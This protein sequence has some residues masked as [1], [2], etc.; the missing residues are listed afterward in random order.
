MPSACLE[1]MCSPC[2]RRFL[3]Q[4]T[5]FPAGSDFHSHKVDISSKAAASVTSGEVAQERTQRQH[6]SSIGKSLQTPLNM[7]DG[8]TQ[9]HHISVTQALGNGPSP[10]LVYVRH[11]AH[12]TPLD[13]PHRWH[14]RR[15]TSLRA[16]W[17]RES[18][19]NLAQR[20]YTYGVCRHFSRHR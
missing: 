17:A 10:G 15:F 18:A 8:S 5:Q 4:A 20:Y 14:S 3:T 2:H 13:S 9:D 12:R 1:C 11:G 16:G 19:M 6:K 7:T